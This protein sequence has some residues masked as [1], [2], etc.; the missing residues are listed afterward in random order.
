MTVPRSQLV[1]LDVTPTTTAFPDAFAGPISAEKATS[2]GNSGSKTG[3]KNWPVSSPSP[4]PAFRSST[5]ICM[6]SFGSKGPN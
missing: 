2:T 4:S 5:T 6:S 3:S 1:D